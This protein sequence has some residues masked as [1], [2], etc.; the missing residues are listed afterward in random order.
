[1]LSPKKYRVV[2]LALLAVV[3]TSVFLFG[4]KSPPSILTETTLAAGSSLIESA[5]NDKQDAAIN[6]EIGKTKSGETASVADADK[7]VGD[8]LFD[9]AQ[10]FLE[11]R[12][13]A[14]MVIFSKTYCPFSK[15][16]K[17]L[18]NDNYRITPEP[19]FVEL[20]K[21]QNGHALQEYVAKITDRRTVPNVILGTQTTKSRGGSD[22]F[23]KLHQE[24][25]LADMLNTW[26]DK[27]LSVVRIEAPSNV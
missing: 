20:D 12:A 22:D 18:L 21:H 9:P 25:K 15:K 27:A 2:L 3:V 1:M 10:A 11:I 13:V 5:N 26:G 16:L 8:S 7:G 14:P 24:G 23:E 6:A 4:R 19:K 17:K